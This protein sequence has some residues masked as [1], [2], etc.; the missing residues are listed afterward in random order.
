MFLI[1]VLFLLVTLFDPSYL[2]AV[3]GAFIGGLI[4]S[5]VVGIPHARNS[6]FKNRFTSGVLLAVLVIV[7]LFI[8]LKGV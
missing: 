4:T 3:I 1:F 6:T 8:G 7:G 2:M 5:F